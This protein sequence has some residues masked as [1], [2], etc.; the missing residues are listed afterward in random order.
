MRPTSANVERE[1]SLA[2]RFV[3]KARTLLGGDT[4]DAFVF[5]R[6]LKDK[7]PADIPAALGLAK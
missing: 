3:T 1:F 4:L 5:A 6:G 7:A 2:G